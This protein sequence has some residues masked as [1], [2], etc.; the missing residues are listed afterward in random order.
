MSRLTAP[1]PS[2]GA[3][4]EFGYASNKA[5]AIDG[6]S[7]ASGSGATHQEGHRKR[8]LSQSRAFMRNNGIYSG[9]VERAVSYITGTGW[10]LES[11]SKSKTWR[12]EV[13]GAFRE[14][15][16]RPE[17]RGML[18]GPRVEAQVCRE[19]LT[20]GDNPTLLVDSAD[21]GGLALQ[22][23]EAEQLASRGG[24]ASSDGIRK[25]KYGQPTAFHLAPYVNGRIALS[26]KDA[27]WYDAD[28]VLYTAHLPRPSQ[29]RADPPSQASF[30][31]L[32]R[33]ADTC[34]SE[35]IARQLLSRMAVAIERDP[36]N[37]K[38][39]AEGDTPAGDEDLLDSRITELGY[40]LIM[41][42]EKGEKVHPIDRSGVPGQD[43]PQ[44]VTMFLRLLGLPLGLPI[45]ITLLD[46]TKSNYSQSRAVL[47]QA[48]NTFKLWQQLLRDSFYAR[49]FEWWVESTYDLPENKRTRRDRLSH[50]W[51]VPTFPWIDQLKEAQAWGEKLDRGFSTH[52]E[53]IR[54]LGGDREKVNM[55]QEQEVRQAIAI[56]KK[57]EKD[58]G[59]LPPW[60]RFCGLKAPK[61]TSSTEQA[62]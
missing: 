41:W 5:A 7:P 30:A 34:D 10:T 42:L 46:W 1:S 8:L 29:W 16:K 18:S 11:T 54:A 31:M 45:E 9:M 53:V 50:S 26:S 57:I 58:T 55:I 23:F 25:G 19:L 21:V 6:R 59:V 40:S 51:G 2:G 22:V 15:W 17:V 32:H 24:R 47:E 4:S 36:E 27:N 13:E 12:E 38:L 48:Y 3:Y 39:G 60:E 35:A 33:I 56:A 61:P 28:S 37:N 44:V 43:F 52:S 62:A 49:L 14:F 20:C